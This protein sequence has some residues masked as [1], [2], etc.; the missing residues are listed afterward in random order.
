[1]SASVLLRTFDG[2][3][4][5][6][7]LNSWLGTTTTED[8]DLLRRVAGP[9]LDVGCGPGR[10]VAALSQQGIVALGVDASP[11]AVEIAVS[12]GIPVLRRSVFDPLPCTGRWATVI[13]L[14]GSIGIGG[15]PTVLLSRVR[16]LVRTGGKVMVEIGG[17][18][19]AS[20]TLTA[21]LESEG[22][23]SEW[24]PWALVGADSLPKLARRSR[25]EI[26]DTW[27]GGERW[28]ASLVKS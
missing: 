22:R 2:S 6:M 11:H 10:H 28:F 7:N 4:V 9:V 12:R 21:R 20:C 3:A 27:N 13:I 25:L 24:F 16:E 17:P 23:H 18:G 26:A 8:D 1:M 14:D 5:P 15:D 19:T